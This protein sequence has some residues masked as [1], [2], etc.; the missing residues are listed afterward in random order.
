MKKALIAIALATVTL[1][2]ACGTAKGIASDTW[3]ATKFV[4]RQINGE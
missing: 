4:A 3:G 2:S 1:T